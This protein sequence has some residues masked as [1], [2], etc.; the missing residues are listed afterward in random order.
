MI[1]KR[2]A[3]AG[4]EF[5]LVFSILTLFATAFLAMIFYN[6]SQGRL[7]D[8]QETTEDMANF[9]Q[10]ELILASKVESGY[11]RTFNLPEKINGKTYSILISNYSLMINTSKAASSRGI[12]ISQGHFITNSEN[13]V[14][15]NDTPPYIFINP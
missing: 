1:L 11:N 10:Q 2:R 8:D 15:K 14:I 3:Q 12:P 6:T 13:T 5:L 9:I 7:K 4:L